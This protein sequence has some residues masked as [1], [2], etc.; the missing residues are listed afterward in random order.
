MTAIVR[1]Q[2]FVPIVFKNGTRENSLPASLCQSRRKRSVGAPGECTILS[3]VR[4]L[5]AA[6]LALVFARNGAPQ[7]RVFLFGPFSHF[8]ARAAAMSGAFTAVANDTTAFYWN[9]A[10]YAFGPAAHG[11]VQWTEREMDRGDG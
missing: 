5:L 10:G 6:A 8:G 7:E 3:R 2:P 9:P 4:L 1:I 11:G